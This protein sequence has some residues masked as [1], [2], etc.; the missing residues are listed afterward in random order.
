MNEKQAR[1]AA[2]RLGVVDRVDEQQ[3]LRSCLR[4]LVAISTLPALWINLK[5]AEI[6]ASLLDL[7][8]T[9]LRLKFTYA[10][11]VQP[12]TREPIE[13]MR[14][15]ERGDTPERARELGVSLDRHLHTGDEDDHDPSFVG[16]TG[17][18]V[19][20]AMNRLGIDGSAG[21]V[22][23]ASERET[24]PTAHER[25]LLSVAANQ[26]AVWLQGSRM[27]AERSD[28]A[29]V[30]ALGADVGRA[31]IHRDPLH[32]ILQHCAE[33]IVANLDAAFARVWTLNEKTNTLELR[34]SAGMY[35]H[36]NGAHS[37]IPVG[38]FKIGQIADERRPHLTNAVIDD[39]RVS[40]PEWA[41]REGMIA[42]AGYPLVVGDR[43]VGVMA[44]FARH[45]LSE[46]TLTALSSVADSIAVGIERLRAEDALRQEVRIR[47]TLGQVGAALAA[48]LDPGKL[49]QAITDAATSLTT[50]QFGAFFYNVRDES[51]DAYQLY[52]ISGAPKEAF[53]RFPQ[54]R[55]TAI[56]GPTFRGE[57][58]VRLAD[59]TLDSRYG[60]NAP[61]HGMPEGH[62]PV[63]SYLAVPVTSRSGEVLGGLFFGHPQPGVFTAQHEQLASGIASWA[64][65]A[66]DNAHLYQRAQ[67]ANRSK[68]EFLATLSH[69]LRTP[70]NALLGWSHMLNSGILT[71]EMQQR[72]VAALER[73][74]R[75]Q[76]QL[77]EDLL[78]VSRVVSG[79][80]HVKSDVVDLSAVVHAAVEV[81]RPTA[82][83]KQIALQVT[84]DPDADIVV[85]GDADRLQQVIWNLLSNAIKFTPSGGRADIELRRSGGDA[86]IRVTD[87]G[88][89]ISR[90]FLPHVFE[91]FRQADSTTIRKHGGLGLGLA[92]VRH[93]TEAHG[94]TV[95]AE[96]AGVGRG[97]TFTLR[98]PIRSVPRPTV[99]IA[100]PL[101]A[102]RSTALVDARVLTVDDQPDAREL[103]RAILEGAGADVTA[104]GSAGEALHALA[105]HVFDLVVAD[106]GMPEQD[107][108]SLIE[109]IRQLPIDQG[110][111]IP[112]VAVTAYAS[113]RERDRALERGY[114]WHVAKPVD[115]DAL[116]AVLGDLLPPRGAAREIPPPG[117]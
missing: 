80:L 97:T 67:D 95:A 41:K 8:F 82:T 55:A 53:A 51:G 102:P 57:G 16:T 60:Q 107:G 85:T 7:L 23:A 56:F 45:P 59:V 96:S 69:E 34:A 81:V 35:T 78:D 62:L 11:L 14:T 50:A 70:L 73:N 21:V 65:V 114:N 33:A 10:R 72:A 32:T 63:R 71:P 6:A 91:R 46:M 93:L 29:H 115:P 5:P 116:I 109:A 43:L 49:V 22:V 17:D 36:L 83:A 111:R 25:L 3:E 61:Y 1:L 48:E 52:T 90:E 40:D 92:L 27:A 64:A 68:D 86:E 110:G 38:S 108:Y 105:H 44:M 99:A 103:M 101:D 15:T 24:F 76:A 47:E 20:L 58:I 84:A 77:V 104:V 18:V 113:P 42:F 75:I 89:G 106:I 12:G 31:V 94:G 26:A 39:P 19:R 13:V 2:G 79:K 74:A 28:R 66:L 9:A 98:L 37:R 117:G 54:P 88:E 112:A 87:T 4:D 30:A 100:T